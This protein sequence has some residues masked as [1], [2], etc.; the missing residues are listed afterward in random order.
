MKGYKIYKQKC[1]IQYLVKLKF[2]LSE[3]KRCGKHND[4]KVPESANWALD[5]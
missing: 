2:T 4:Q 1:L 3:W 5:A